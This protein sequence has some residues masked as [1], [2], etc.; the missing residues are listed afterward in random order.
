MKCQDY[1]SSSITFEGHQS[2]TK[3]ETRKERIETAKVLSCVSTHLR[4]CKSLLRQLNCFFSHLPIKHIPLP[5][6]LIQLERFF[7][8]FFDIIIWRWYSVQLKAQR[9]WQLRQWPVYR[10]KLFQHHLSIALVSTPTNYY[11]W[12]IRTSSHN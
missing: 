3:K 4:Y 8:S 9:L 1:P 12:V 2:K 6:H 5:R 7:C 11:I 10:F